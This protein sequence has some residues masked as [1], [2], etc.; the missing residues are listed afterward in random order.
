MRKASAPRA[1][2]QRAVPLRQMSPGWWC[3]KGSATMLACAAIVNEDRNGASMARP[4]APWPSGTSMEWMPSFSEDCTTRASSSS[5]A[6]EAHAKAPAL[7]STNARAASEAF[8]GRSKR[9]RRVRRWPAVGS[10]TSRPCAGSTDTTAGGKAFTLPRT[11][12]MALTGGNVTSIRPPTP[13][14]NS[15]AF[16]SAKASTS[17]V[18]C[19]HTVSKPTGRLELEL[20]FATTM[21]RSAA[22]HP[23]VKMSTCATGSAG[24]STTSHSSEPKLPK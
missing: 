5:Q 3:E 19:G 9:R 17:V 6:T 11:N 2:W 14:C 13:T 8:M 7:P 16:F 18:P 1:R 15:V 12:T 20:K 21:T 24:V 23:R 10:C 22:E 4:S